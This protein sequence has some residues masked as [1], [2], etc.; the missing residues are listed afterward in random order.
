MSAMSLVLL[1]CLLKTKTHLYK[2]NR[3]IE[4]L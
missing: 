2:T 3:E 4:E 1:P